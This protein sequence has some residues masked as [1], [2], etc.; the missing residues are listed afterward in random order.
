MCVRSITALNKPN[1]K[2][3]T[4]KGSLANTFK[5]HAAISIAA[6]ASGKSL[7]QW[8]VDVLKQAAV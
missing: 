2:P 7:N 6:S 1:E 3:T 8:A 5:D 4:D